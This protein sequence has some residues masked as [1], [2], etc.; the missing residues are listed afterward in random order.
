MSI[1]K[2][3]GYEHHSFVTIDKLII[4]QEKEKINI[5]TYRRI[6]VGSEAYLIMSGIRIGNEAIIL[7]DYVITNDVPDNETKRG[8]PALGAED[9]YLIKTKSYIA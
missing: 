1:K 4:F 5:N 8:F 2:V 7:A 9:C 3:L 6:I